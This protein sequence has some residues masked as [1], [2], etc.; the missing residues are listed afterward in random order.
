LSKYKHATIQLI[1]V[2]HFILVHKYL[3]FNYT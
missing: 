2:G 3:F 1:E